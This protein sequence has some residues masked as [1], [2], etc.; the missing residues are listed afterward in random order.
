MLDLQPPR[1]TPTLPTSRRPLRAK[2][3]PLPDGL[4]NGSSRP[5]AE[6]P[7]LPKGQL[8]STAGGIAQTAEWVLR[9][10]RSRQQPHATETS[11][12]RPL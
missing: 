2:K 12:E 7:F 3:R 9:P 8:S 5:S 11:K 4:A 10:L 6:I 1:H